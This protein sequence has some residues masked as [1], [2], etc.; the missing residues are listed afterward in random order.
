MMF[1]KIKK[2]VSSVFFLSAV[3]V[4]SAP[5]KTLLQPEEQPKAVDVVMGLYI[6]LSITLVLLL[7]RVFPKTF[8]YGAEGWDSNYTTAIGRQ[9]PSSIGL[10]VGILI[11]ELGIVRALFPRTIDILK[12]R[13]FGDSQSNQS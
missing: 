10:T 4:C 1:M 8:M 5:V 13:Y 6:G 3:T 12:E 9:W 2:L 7:S 11:A